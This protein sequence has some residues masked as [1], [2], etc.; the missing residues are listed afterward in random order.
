MS[1]FI[2][3]TVIKKQDDN[4]KKAEDKKSK[5]HTTEYLC[6]LLQR[7]QLMDFLFIGIKSTAV[8]SEK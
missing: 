2:I 1:M 5:C 8:N 7:K 6:W 3:L 4:G